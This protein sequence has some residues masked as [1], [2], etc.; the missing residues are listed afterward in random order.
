L[1][2]E[3]SDGLVDVDLDCEEAVRAADVLLPATGLVSGRAGAPRSHRWYRVDDPPRKAA[4]AF[5]DP[6]RDPGDDRRV[7]ELRST[8]GQTVCPPSV[9]PEGESYTWDSAGE[10]AAVP[11]AELRVAVA[12]TAA[13]ALL[14]RYWPR[15]GRNAAALALAGGLL[16]AG[17]DAVRVETFVRAVCA[18]ARDE[19]VGNRVGAV[20]HP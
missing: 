2:G 10:P 11:V 20:W 6:V 12:A 3:A 4:E 13:A 18:A 16:R 7:A 15:G 14:G 1:L 8:G 19:E 17:W 9:H 5:D